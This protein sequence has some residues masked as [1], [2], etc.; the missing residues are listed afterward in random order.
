[1]RLILSWINL[2]VPQL[3]P[4]CNTH[5]VWS[6]STFLSRTRT[7]AVIS[8][9]SLL[10]NLPQR[11]LASETNLP[12]T[13]Q[14]FWKTVSWE[15]PEVLKSFQELILLKLLSLFTMGFK[16]SERQKT[17]YLPFIELEKKDISTDCIYHWLVILLTSRYPRSGSPVLSLLSKPCIFM[18]EELNNVSTAFDTTFSFIKQTKKQMS[19]AECPRC[20]QPNWNK[21]PQ[22]YALWLFSFPAFL[23]HRELGIC[24]T[25]NK[26]TVK[27]SS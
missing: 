9:Q 3:R 16:T 6:G 19:C 1:M 21:R 8:C 23:A 18:A 20:Y 13:W 14:I 2:L 5:I 17:T 7:T 4:S 11:S 10:Q 22:G 24:F 25:R 12:K 15:S 27:H 26:N